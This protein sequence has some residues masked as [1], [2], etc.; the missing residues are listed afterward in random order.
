MD[1]TPHLTGSFKATSDS[2]KE[3]FSLEEVEVDKIYTNK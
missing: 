2:L 1:V 3:T